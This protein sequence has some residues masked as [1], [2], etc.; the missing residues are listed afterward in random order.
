M[1][2]NITKIKVGDDVRC[3]SLD[4]LVIDTRTLGSN[5][6]GKLGVKLGSS[7]IVDYSGIGV[8]LG[9][10]MIVDYYGIGVKIHPDTYKYLQRESSGLSLKLESM[11]KDIFMLGTLGFT[12]DG[13]NNLKIGTSAESLKLGTG[14]KG[15]DDGKTLCLSLGSGLEF[16]YGKEIRLKVDDEQG[17]L[18]TPS[19][20]ALVFNLDKLYE[21][22]EARYNLTK[23]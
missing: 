1:S 15:E 5:S 17:L 22:L 11:V 13:Y 7:M 8:K 21:L 3:I 14:L 12:I 23:K 20:G 10:S 19:G 16:S 6:S 4:T 9:S 2:E 18:V